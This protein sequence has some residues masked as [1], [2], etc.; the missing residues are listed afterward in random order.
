M[1]SLKRT[2]AL[3]FRRKGKERLT[4]REFVF[5]AS[6][7]LGWFPPKDAQRLL[8]VGLKQGLLAR[9]EG[10]VRPQFDVAS[11]DIPLDFAP[12]EAVLE[13][14]DLFQRL[15]DVVASV[16]GRPRKEVVARTNAIQGRMG[17]YAE[18]A[19]LLTG[20]AWDVDLTSFR[21]EVEEQVQQRRP[22][23]PAG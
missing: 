14:Q 22:S 15:V 16:S 11:T 12:T 23:P 18:V 8:D 21:L 9:E 7:D 10:G 17:I 6:M 13:E 1:E 4:E 19:V 20:A 3:L 2:I 5:S